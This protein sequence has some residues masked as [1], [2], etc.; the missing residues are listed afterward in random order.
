MNGRWHF[1]NGYPLP[2]QHSWSRWRAG[3]AAVNVAARSSGADPAQH[4]A[5]ARR[6]AAESGVILGQPELQAPAKVSAPV[7]QKNAPHPAVL[8][9]LPADQPP[10]FEAPCSSSGAVTA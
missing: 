4:I 5:L 8:A 2:H 9:T 7:R 1:L 6:Q 3:R 10:G